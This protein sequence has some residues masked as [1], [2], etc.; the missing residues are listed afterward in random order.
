[1][2]GASYTH[3]TAASYTHVT[4]AFYTHVTAASYKSNLKSLRVMCSDS[5]AR[6][7]PR[8]GSGPQRE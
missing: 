1:M 6:P 3:V 4:A 8:L 2:I 5:D 7:R